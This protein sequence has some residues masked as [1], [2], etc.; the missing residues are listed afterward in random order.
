MRAAEYVFFIDCP[1][2]P[3]AGGLLLRNHRFEVGFKTCSTSIIQDFFLVLLCT[4]LFAVVEIALHLPPPRTLC[5]FVSLCDSLF[6]PLRVGTYKGG[7]CNPIPRTAK[8]PGLLYL[9]LFHDLV[10]GDILFNVGHPFSHNVP[11]NSHAIP[12]LC[13]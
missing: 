1:F 9:V 12:R 7:E 10:L 2:K 13:G 5:L 8:K 3:T 11:L 4:R 6:V